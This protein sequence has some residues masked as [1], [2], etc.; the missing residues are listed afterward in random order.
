[1]AEQEIKLQVKDI[2]VIGS[3]RMMNDSG[4]LAL[5]PSDGKTKT[6]L[7]TANFSDEKFK[8][9]SSADGYVISAP[10]GS[11]SDQSNIPL[12]VEKPIPNEPRQL[13]KKKYQ[14]GGTLLISDSN[15]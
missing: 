13:W 15:D 9:L 14:Q 5:F 2:L 11:I 6:Q 1:M 4:R 7:W 3:K 8:I 12:L 10:Q